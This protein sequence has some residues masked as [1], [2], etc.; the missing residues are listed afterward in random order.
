MSNLVKIKLQGKAHDV[1]AITYALRQWLQ[2]LDDAERRDPSDEEIVKRY[3]TVTRADQA[4]DL[5]GPV[6]YPAGS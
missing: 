6:D 5:D 2:V 3:L 1:E 4:V